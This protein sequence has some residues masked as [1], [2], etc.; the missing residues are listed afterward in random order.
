M[1]WTPNAGLINFG[2]GG[3]GSTNVVVTVTINP[4]T[5]QYGQTVFNSPFNVGTGTLNVTVSPTTPAI[6]A[7]TTFDVIIAKTA[8]SFTVTSG[9]SGWRYQNNL[10]IG[11]GYRAFRITKA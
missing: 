5:G 10:D 6:P 7:G 9:P 1:A 11:N 2:G 8:L 3:A 4:V